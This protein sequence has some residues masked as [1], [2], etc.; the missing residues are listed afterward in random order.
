MEDKEILDYLSLYEK[1]KLDEEAIKNFLTD[2]GVNFDINTAKS[3][4][5][6]QILKLIKEQQSVKYSKEELISI[7]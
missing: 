6:E 2:M 7:F 4:N 1:G 3:M 5:S